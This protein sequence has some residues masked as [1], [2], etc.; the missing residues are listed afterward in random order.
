MRNAPPTPPEVKGR[1]G[2][3]QEVPDH[4]VYPSMEFP[5]HGVSVLDILHTRMQ[6]TQCDTRAIIGSKLGSKHLAFAQ[7]SATLLTGRRRLSGR[8][9]EGVTLIDPVEVD[10][11]I[12]GLVYQAP[13][14][15]LRAY[16]QGTHLAVHYDGV[17]SNV[18]LQELIQVAERYG[19]QR[20]V[21]SEPNYVAFG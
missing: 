4:S 13:Q 7:E 12:P 11:Q 6:Q 5:P 2:D 3:S 18:V 14:Y 17:L 21:E 15:N 9:L 20:L 10:I 8:R 16:V 19:F 1:E